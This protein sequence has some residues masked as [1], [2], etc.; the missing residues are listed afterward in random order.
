MLRDNYGYRAGTSFLNAP[1]QPIVRSIPLNILGKI[2]ICDY[3]Q[4][5]IT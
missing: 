2:S 5:I 4:E 1:H 3:R